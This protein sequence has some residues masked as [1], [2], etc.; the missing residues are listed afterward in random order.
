[1]ANVNKTCYLLLYH[2]ALNCLVCEKIA[3]LCRPTAHILVMTDRRTNRWTA[4][5]RKGALIV[6]SGE[7]ITSLHR[8]RRFI[9]HLL[10]YLL[11]YLLQFLKLKFAK[12]S[13]GVF[14]QTL[15]MLY[16]LPTGW[17]KQRQRRPA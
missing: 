2:R 14:H 17:R 15:P 5:M 6:A 16:R 11:T 7:L 12:F 9:N 8:R 10:T 4:S 13:S 3:I 1:V